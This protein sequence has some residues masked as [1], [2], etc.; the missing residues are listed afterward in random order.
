[1]TKSFFR[2]LTSFCVATV[3]SA[4]TTNPTLP[5]VEA[6][7]NQP[8]MTLEDFE[9]IALQSN[10]TLRQA[11]SLVAQSAAQAKQAGLYPNPSV[12]YDGEQIRGGSYGGGEQGA[13]V[14]QTF[15]L[16]GKLATRR[17][18]Y[19]QQRR[20]GEIG[21]AEQKI[22]IHGDIGQRFYSTLAAQEV[23]NTRKHLLTVSL[24]AVETGR[25][26]A[27]VGQA[28][29][30][31]V[32]QAE[33]EA[34]QAKIDYTAAQYAFLQQFRSLAAVAGK[35]EL[36]L[37]S[38]KGNL[39]QP[40]NLDQSR[41]LEQLLKDSPMVQRAQQE[42]RS[43]DA[44]LKNAR[45]ESIPDLQIRA[46]LQQNL[47]S[48]D[49]TGRRIVGLQGFAS[50]GITLPIFNRN[51]G[52]VA[53]AKAAVE[54]A[55]AEVVRTQLMLRQDAQPLLQNYLSASSEAER[56]RTE[57]IPRATRAYHLY[58]AKYQNMA[59]AYPQVLISQ[60]TL[61]QLQI[62]YIDALAGVWKN[63]IALQNFM[64][65]SGL[66]GPASRTIAPPAAGVGGPQAP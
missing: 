35:S 43:A 3:L 28:D 55:Q 18:V 52:N 30:P 51:Q 59:A 44:E 60:R 53:A 26:L 34:E 7:A 2:T 65:G 15:I 27:N 62:S 32:L 61:F 40:P 49:A 4:A 64:L 29:T 46:G 56:Y 33:V 37:C 48:L 24:D 10:P 41:V 5:E 63:A 31:D 50:A 9:G 39:E 42:I 16:G 54:I 21:Q 38:L 66:T 45:R 36:A 19:E 23:M 47:E 20:Q 13:F 22:R 58:L 17:D 8:A 1:M 11:A 12:G 14:Q 57:M 25:Q 6:A